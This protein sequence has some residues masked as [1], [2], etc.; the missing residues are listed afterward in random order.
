MDNQFPQATDNLRDIAMIRG[1]LEIKQ[2]EK[3][4]KEISKVTFKCRI[5]IP[6]YI[7]KGTAV[8]YDIHNELSLHAQ[9]EFQCLSNRKVKALG[10]VVYS[11]RNMNQL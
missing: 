8:L 11:I 1:D 4:E 9:S 6:K 5:L 2:I 3:S 10:S 7:S